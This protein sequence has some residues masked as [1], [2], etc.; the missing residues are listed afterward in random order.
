MPPWQSGQPSIWFNER[1]SAQQGLTQRSV[2]GHVPGD[3]NASSRGS[4]REQG[5]VATSKRS[6][7]YCLVRGWVGGIVT[8]TDPPQEAL[9]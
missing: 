6:E 2:H 1:M 8:C 3:A 9:G 5:R 4:I 7:L